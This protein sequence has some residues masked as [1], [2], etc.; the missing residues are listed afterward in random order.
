MGLLNKLFGMTGGGRLAKALNALTA[1]F[2]FDSLNKE[3][4]KSIDSAVIQLLMTGSR[5]TFVEAMPWARG[6]EK[7]AYYGLVAEVF[8]QCGVP[9]V[10]SKCFVGGRWNSV[11]NPLI[12]L[13]DCDDEIRMARVDIFKRHQVD[14]NI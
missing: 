13:S 14:V 3:D 9:P 8:L 7:V 5:I 11:D 2:M 4:Q 6:L 12:G 1:K 10:F